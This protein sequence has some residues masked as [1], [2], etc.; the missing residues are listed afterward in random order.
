MSTGQEF[1][2]SRTER[3]V[4]EERR[5]GEAAAGAAATA[6][7]RAEEETSLRN[8]TKRTGEKTQR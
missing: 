4:G 3:R 2:S 6:G 7:G 5:A 8:S 1:A